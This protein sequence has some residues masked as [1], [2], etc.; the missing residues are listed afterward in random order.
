M[1]ALLLWFWSFSLLAWKA[2]TMLNSYTGT[3]QPQSKVSTYF[4][5]IFLH[6]SKYMQSMQWQVKYV[7]NIAYLCLSCYGLHSLNGMSDKFISW[8]RCIIDWTPTIA[9]HRNLVWHTFLLTNSHFMTYMPRGSRF[10]YTPTKLSF[11]VCL[12]AIWKGEHFFT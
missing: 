10:N 8:A 9:L 3:K 6:I 7:Q 1:W 11:T 12:D 2:T 4:Q 5:N